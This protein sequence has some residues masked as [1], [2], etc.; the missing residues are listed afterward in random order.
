MRTIDFLFFYW[1]IQI[2]QYRLKKQRWANSIICVWTALTNNCGVLISRKAQ[3]YVFVET[4]SVG[5]LR[6]H[7]KSKDQFANM[8]FL[9]DTLKSYFLPDASSIV[10]NLVCLLNFSGGQC[11]GLQVL[12]ISQRV[13]LSLKTMLTWSF[14]LQPSLLIVSWPLYLCEKDIWAITSSSLSAGFC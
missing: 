10:T 14:M 13:V 2:R 11:Q 6:I 3:T 9:Q 12:G 8:Q 7:A 5:L 1:K 4:K